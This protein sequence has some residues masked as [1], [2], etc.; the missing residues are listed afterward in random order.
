MMFLLSRCAYLAPWLSPGWFAIP[1]RLIVGYGFVEHGYAKLARGPESFIAILHAI[2]VPAPGL[3]AW[4][5]ILVELLGGFAVL[6][7]AF[8]PLA[9]APMA[10]VLLVAIFTPSAQWL[11]FDQAG[12]G[13]GR[14]RPF[15]S[16]G[17]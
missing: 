12:I 6:V 3:M 10:A 8:V 4:T 15:R 11:Q 14:R 5:T 9:S 16:T 13:D 2:G 7:G 17:L 1:L